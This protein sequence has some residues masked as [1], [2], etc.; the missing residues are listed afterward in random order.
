MV[1]FGTEMDDVM[2]TEENTV[3]RQAYLKLCG[4]HRTIFNKSSLNCVFL[5]V[6]ENVR[7]TRM[8]FVSEKSVIAFGSYAYFSEMKT[9]WP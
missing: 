9:L 4:Y 7:R 8:F 1:Q 3:G 6:I 5:D 2:V